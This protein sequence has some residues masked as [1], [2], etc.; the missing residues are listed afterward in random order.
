[1]RVKHVEFGTWFALQK[2][3]FLMPPYDL[4]TLILYFGKDKTMGW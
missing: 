4:V 3:M 1:M 2:V